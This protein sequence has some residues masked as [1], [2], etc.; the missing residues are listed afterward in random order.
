MLSRKG[1]PLSNQRDL[2]QEKSKLAWNAKVALDRF[3]RLALGAV[4][5][6]P[7][8]RTLENMVCGEI[9]EPESERGVAGIAVQSFEMLVRGAGWE[10]DIETRRV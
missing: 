9:R 5:T 1:R 2:S 6:R 10:P 3:P 7:G 4:L 8:W